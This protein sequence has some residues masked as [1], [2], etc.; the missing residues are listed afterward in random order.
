MSLYDDIKKDVGPT[1]PGNMPLE[2]G[3]WYTVACA[4]LV[5]P[6]MRAVRDRCRAAGMEA[7]TPVQPEL[8]A[9]WL[10]DDGYARTAYTFGVIVKPLSR[11]TAGYVGNIAG[12]TGSS[13]MVLSSDIGASAT[14]DN[15]N[16]AQKVQDGIGDDADAWKDKIHAGLPSWQTITFIAVGLALFVAMK[17]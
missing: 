3:K 14:W 16:N 6:D 10:D 5:E 4:T 15:M 1:L 13:G 17:K 7:V 11:V 9:N 12:G 2:A 8:K